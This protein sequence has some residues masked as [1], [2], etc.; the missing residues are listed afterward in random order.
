MD[1]SRE[2]DIEQL[3]ARLFDMSVPYFMRCVMG[4]SLLKVQREM[5]D[6]N[7]ANMRQQL[8]RATINNDEKMVEQIGYRIKQ[9]Q[10][11]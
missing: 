2:A 11:G 10:R 7:I 8:I 9:Y 1:R 6:R 3:K 4:R 5:K